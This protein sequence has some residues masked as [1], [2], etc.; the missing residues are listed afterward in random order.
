MGMGIIYFH[1]LDN[2][3]KALIH[4]KCSQ[5]EQAPNQKPS[6]TSFQMMFNSMWPKLLTCYLPIKSPL[7]KKGG[8]SRRGLRI[9][10]HQSNKTA[11]ALF[12]TG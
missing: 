2:V 1:I 12:F 3:P 9:N 4:S 6:V 8:C 7:L 5:F 10:L 11:A